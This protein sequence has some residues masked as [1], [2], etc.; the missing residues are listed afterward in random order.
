MFKGLCT[1]SRLGRLCTRLLLEWDVLSLFFFSRTHG[2]AEVAETNSL[3]AAVRFQQSCEVLWLLNSLALNLGHICPYLLLTPGF[4]PASSLV[5]L[6]RECPQQWETHCSKQMC[7]QRL[8]WSSCWCIPAQ[9]GSGP[10]GTV[11]LE[12]TELLNPVVIAD[13]M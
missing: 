1:D 7:L 11:W 13:F 4:L 9:P 12:A 2:V 10:F 5:R 6:L 3:A 8:D